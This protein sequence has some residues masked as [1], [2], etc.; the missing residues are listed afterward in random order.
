VLQLQQGD[1]GS[2]LR[3]ATIH[4]PPVLRINTSRPLQGHL[5]AAKTLL[6]LLMAYLALWGPYFILHLYGIT[7]GVL[8]DPGT[9]ELVALW[10]GFTSFAVNPFLYGWMNKAIREELV[11]LYRRLL[12]RWCCCSG[13]VQ[14]TWL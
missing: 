2:T 3:P 8:Y 11:S 14:L 13:C 1:F 4:E 10:L 6:M 7:H 5:K 12:C 9:T